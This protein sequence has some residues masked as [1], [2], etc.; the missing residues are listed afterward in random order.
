MKRLLFLV[1]LVAVVWYGW[2]HR[3][4]LLTGNTD[5]EA[6]LVNEGTREMLRV[7]LTVDGRTYVRDEIAPGARTT[8]PIAVS[9]TSDFRLRW[10]WKGLEGAPDWRGGEIAPGPP[11]SRC[12]ITMYDDNDPA[13]ACVPMPTA[14]QAT[15]GGPQSP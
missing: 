3:G 13:V 14:G 1:F 11:R 9:R 15:P 6:V 7:R 10:E 8:I 2:N 12:T 4:G 5:S